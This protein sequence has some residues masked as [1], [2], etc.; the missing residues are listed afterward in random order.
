MSTAPS[1]ERMVGLYGVH[2]DKPFEI[3]HT[4]LDVSVRGESSPECLVTIVHKTFIGHHTAV[5]WFPVSEMNG[6]VSFAV[7][8]DDER[9]VG[10]LRKSTGPGPSQTTPVP[11]QA[12]RD[13]NCLYYFCARDREQLT[14][15]PVNKVIDLKITYKTALNRIEEF[16][17]K[18]QLCFMMPVA[19]CFP[20]GIDDARIVVEMKERIRSIYSGML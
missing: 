16:D 5:L 15:L 8:I 10:T 17:K 2:N 6:A 20:R 3:R 4:R 1:W 12:P 11:P 18:K 9:V 19:S 7:E 13:P 14:D